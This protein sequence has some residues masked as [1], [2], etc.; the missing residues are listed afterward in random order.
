MAAISLNSISL[1]PTSFG[2]PIFL[3]ISIGLAWE[4][5]G[6]ILWEGRMIGSQ[7]RPCMNL[8]GMYRWFSVV[9]QGLD[10]LFP[11]VLFGGFRSLFLVIFLERFRGLSWD[12][13]GD[14]CMNLS[15][16]FSL[17][18]LSQIHEQR[19]S[20]LGLHKSMERFRRSGVG[21][22]GVDPRVLFIP[23]YPRVTGQTGAPH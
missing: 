8:F 14:V 17:W 7:A 3:R 22:G 4:L 9:P 6:E 10:V 23:S 2:F 20:I 13:V 5:H 12:L 18:F 1:N 15:W 21:F 11:F 19:G 16:F